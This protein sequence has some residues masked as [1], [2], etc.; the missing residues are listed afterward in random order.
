MLPLVIHHHHGIGR[1]FHHE[2]HA[3][4]CALELRHIDDR[5]DIAGERAAR[6]EAGHAD[7]EDRA[8]LAVVPAQAVL[9][10]KFPA[11]IERIV[12]RLKAQVE[13]LRMDS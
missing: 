4:L 9:H 2:L 5:A 1:G 13:V 11:R 10:R 3:L 6:I 8:I 12:V 7:V